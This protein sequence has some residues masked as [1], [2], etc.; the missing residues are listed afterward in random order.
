[1]AGKSGDESRFAPKATPPAPTRPI[2]IERSVD[3]GVLIA[4][5][6][7]V[8]DVKNL[9]IVDAIRDGSTFDVDNVTAAVRNELRDLAEENESSA[10]R[11]QQL[12]VDVQTR[13]GPRDNSEGYQVDDHPTLTKRGIIHVMLAAELE[14]LSEDPEFLAG[15]AERARVQAWA[16]VGGAIESRLLESVSTSVDPSYE[17]EKPARVRALV[18]INLRALEKQAKRRARR[19]H[20]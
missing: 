18:D 14:R 13:R 17:E 20:S 19:S 7:V 10:N 6:A 16:E 12:S 1:M 2:S 15:L 11:V 3:E 4:S 9:I 8:M 5:A